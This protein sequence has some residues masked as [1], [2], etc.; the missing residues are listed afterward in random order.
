PV[1]GLS[2]WGAIAWQKAI[3]ALP[4][5]ATPA[6]KGNDIDHTP[7]WLWSAGVDFTAID[8]LRVSLNARG[9]SA[10]YLELANAT[11]RFGDIAV[12][13]ADIA[14]ALSSLVELGLAAKNLTGS[15]YEY[16]WWDGAQSLHSPASDTNFTA[17][18]R[19][20]F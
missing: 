11:D 13:D 17:S 1:D 8:R 5:P 18:V 15:Y 19:L 10:Y 16:V 2:F 14:Y 6:L 12:V 4:D 20:R 7:R 3:I 9:Q